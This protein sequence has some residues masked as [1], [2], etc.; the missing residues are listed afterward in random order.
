[1]GNYD[2]EIDT[3]G[4]NCPRPVMLANK[5]FSGLSVGQTL[6]IISTDPGSVKD[7]AAFCRNTDH[8]LI[9]SNQESNKFIYFVKKTA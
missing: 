6:K 7:L 5:A 2:L 4:M 3:S 1:M 9:S 8:V